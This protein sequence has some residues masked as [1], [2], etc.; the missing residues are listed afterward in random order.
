[1]TS[2]NW[3]ITGFE[4]HIYEIKFTKTKMI[5]TIDGN[6]IGENNYYLSDNLK[7]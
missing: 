7:D 5:I 4:D 6:L 2:N 1:M 3:I